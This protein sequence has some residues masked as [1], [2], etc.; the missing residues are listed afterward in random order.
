MARVCSDKTTDDRSY[1]ET[2]PH[3]P[4]LLNEVIEALSPQDGEIFV[5][6]TFGAGG[7]TRA[8]LEAADCAVIA[9]DRDPD[10]IEAGRNLQAQFGDRLKLSHGCYG[11]MKELAQAHGFHKVDGVTL[12]LGVS[13][14]QLDQSERGF[15]FNNDGPLDMRMGQ[16]GPSATDI[17]NSIDE[18]LLARIIALYGE[19]RKAR[20]IARAIGRVRGDMEISRTLELADIVSQTIGQP[21]GLQKIHPAT[22]TFQALRIY[23]NDE[24]GELVRG[25]AAAEHML[26]DGGRLAVVTFHSL[27]DRI[28]KKFLAHR[29]G[30]AGRPSRH[31]PEMPPPAPSFTELTRK[32][33]K[34]TEDEISHN[35]RSRSARLRAA[36]RTGA[37]AFALDE[38]LFKAPADDSSGV[39]A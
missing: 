13:S 15:S 24:L 3:I 7:Y 29:T 12:D 34:A 33:T 16:V 9:I 10:A 21:A 32:G 37:P 22:R 23:V 8:L 27:E 14:M 36:R 31:M 1:P 11:D 2:R 6:G 25:L 4:V 30:R 18:K 5:D 39:R 38:V 20:E 26:G 19:E 35:P 28:A 17:I